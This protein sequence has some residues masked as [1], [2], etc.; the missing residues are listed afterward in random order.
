MFS[1]NDNTKINRMNKK[2]NKLEKKIKPILIA[3][4]KKNDEK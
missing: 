4:L 3:C 2:L 1:V